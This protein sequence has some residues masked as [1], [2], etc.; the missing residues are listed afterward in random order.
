[1]EV[2]YSRRHY[3]P[4]SAYHLSIDKLRTLEPQII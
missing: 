4:Q 3:V 2:T 1:M